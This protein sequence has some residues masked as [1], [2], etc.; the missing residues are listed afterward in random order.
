MQVELP[1]EVRADVLELV[2]AGEF[3]SPEAAVVELVRVGLGYRYRRSPAPRAPG[4]PRELP[5]RPGLP[6]D[7]NWMR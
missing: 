4:E 7:V 2:A 3:A 6:D 5:Q 1:P